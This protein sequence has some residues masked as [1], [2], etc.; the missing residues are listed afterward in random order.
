[1]LTEIPTEEF[2]AVLDACA[3]EVLWEAGV[4]RPPIDAVLVARR[5]GIVVTSNE[6]LRQRGRFVRLADPC[7]GEARQGTIVVG[8]AE[9]PE[10]MQ[11]AIAHEIGE[12][13]AHRVFQ[14]LNIQGDSAPQHARECVANQLANCLLLP[15]KWFNTDGRR[16]NW[17]LVALKKRYSTASH[18]LV[19]RRMLDLS[20]PIVI[21]LCDQGKIRW[22]RSN[23]MPRPPQLLPEEAD[24]WR[25]THI[26]G[27]TTWI[28]LNCAHTGLESVQCWPVHEPDWKREILRSAI[29]E[30]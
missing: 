21:T 13:V 19:A 3:S 2:N 10:R 22:R 12:C 11:W 5:L 6:S 20:P 18:E 24:A 25:T 4:D 26:T 27:R 30:T 1:M 7:G 15:R 29:V 16:L 9:R 8:P 17:D 23:A 14:S 28:D